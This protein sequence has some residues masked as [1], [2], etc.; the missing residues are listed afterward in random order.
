MLRDKNDILMFALDHLPQLLRISPRES[1][2]KWLFSSNKI[3][4]IWETNKNTNSN[5]FF[6]YLGQITVTAPTSGKENSSFP[7][8]S[9]LFL[10]EWTN[11]PPQFFRRYQKLLV[12]LAKGTPPNRWL[13]RN[14]RVSGQLF[15]TILMRL[16]DQH[17]IPAAPDHFWVGGLAPWWWWW[18][19]YRNKRAE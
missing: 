7:K 18:R 15:K 14:R 6:L 2:A 19:R 11:R 16:W 12:V 1:V 17:T 13:C 9:H 3:S 4:V 10:R 5:V 8:H